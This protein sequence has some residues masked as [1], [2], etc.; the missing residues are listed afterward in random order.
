M[1]RHGGH[2]ESGRAVLRAPCGVYAPS[3]ESWGML[4]RFSAVFLDYATSSQV[5]RLMLL[6][7]VAAIVL[8]VFARSL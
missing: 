8:Y 3:E 2:A 4:P 5:M 6:A 1:I 7:V